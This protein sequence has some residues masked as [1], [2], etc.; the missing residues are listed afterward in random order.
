MAH[1]NASSNI[2]PLRQPF[3]FLTSALAAGILVDQWI[4][5]PFW[6]T[7]FSLLLLIG[8]GIACYRATQNTWAA[9]FILAGFTAAGLSLSG[10]VRRSARSDGLKRLME[11]GV[12][13]ASDPVRLLGVLERPPEPVPDGVLI[14]IRARE[15]MIALAS[16]GCFGLGQTHATAR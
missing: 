11:D 3:I 8:L 7:T 14:D 12:I 13:T 9:M 16:R 2:S 1:P 5:P 10:A 15:L 4:W 6:M